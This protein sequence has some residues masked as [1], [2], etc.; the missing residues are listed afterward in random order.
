MFLIGGD[1]KG[2][3]YGDHPSLTDL[4][5]GNLKWHTDFRSVYATI[6]ENWLGVSSTPILGA[7]FNTLNFV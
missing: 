7:S 1:V 4:D 6:L 2:G 3:I 5:F